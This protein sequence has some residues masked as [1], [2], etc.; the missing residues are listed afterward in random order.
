M[1]EVVLANGGTID[2]YIGD[3]VMAFWNAPLDDSDH[4][5]HAARAALE[6]IGALTDLNTR[7]QMRAQAGGGAH[8]NIR[9]GIGLATGECCVGNFG[10][11]RRFDHSALEAAWR[12]AP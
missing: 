7:R 12:H 10:S 3:A 2:K 11:I 4:A 1:T 9:F 6:M 8:E 5:A